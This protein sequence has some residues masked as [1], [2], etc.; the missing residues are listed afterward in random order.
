VRTVAGSEEVVH[1]EA[2]LKLL[3]DKFQIAG[4]R[5]WLLVILEDQPLVGPILHAAQP[6][7]LFWLMPRFTGKLSPYLDEPAPFEDAIAFAVQRIMGDPMGLFPGGRPDT[8]AGRWPVVSHSTEI[9]WEHG[10]IRQAGLRDTSCGLW[11]GNL[12]LN[13][14]GEEV[15]LA[16]FEGLDGFT[17]QAPVVQ[18]HFA[19]PVPWA[20]VNGVGSIHVH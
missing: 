18:G 13:G 12:L 10:S 19:A 4:R 1:S 9:F 2:L 7:L 15:M 17:S 20:V 16:A 3:Q 14:M 5:V 6:E 8:P 11:A